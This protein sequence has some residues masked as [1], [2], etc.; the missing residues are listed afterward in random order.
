MCL[1]CKVNYLYCTICIDEKGKCILSIVRVLYDK[2][3]HHI[4]PYYD[5]VKAINAFFTKGLYVSVWELFNKDTFI[6]LLDNL[7]YNADE[8]YTEE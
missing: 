6:E 1:I 7:F 3:D 5:V 4:E 8:L 2:E